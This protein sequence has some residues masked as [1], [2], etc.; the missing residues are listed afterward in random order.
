MTVARWTGELLW[1]QDLPEGAF[2]RGSD[3]QP[4][5]LWGGRLHAYLGDSY[6]ESTGLGSRRVAAVL[7]PEPIVNVLR[8]GYRPEIRL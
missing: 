6:G 7:T 5:L 3:G 2:V 1:P 8:A 4:Q